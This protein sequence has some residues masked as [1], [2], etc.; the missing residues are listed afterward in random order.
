MRTPKPS[1]GASKRVTVVDC[2]SRAPVDGARLW[3]ILF[4]GDRREIRE[5]VTDALGE[6]DLPD[7]IWPDA[8]LLAR[9]R[10]YVARLDQLKH[11]DLPEL[12][13][14]MPGLPVSGTVSLADGCPAAGAT[15]YAWDLESRGEVAREAALIDPYF[16]D[17]IV[18]D[19]NGCFEIDGVVP[20]QDF[21]LSVVVPGRGV[22]RAVH[23]PEPELR[24]SLAAGGALEGRVLDANGAAVAVAEVYAE[25]EPDADGH[26]RFDVVSIDGIAARTVTD[27]T[28]HYCLVDLA[29]ARYVVT[30]SSGCRARGASK[31]AVIV[32]A[33]DR[34]WRDVT[35]EQYASVSVTLVNPPTPKH[36]SIHCELLHL[37]GSSSW[38]RLWSN[39]YRQG[40]GID[41]IF[42][43]RDGIHPGVYRLEVT[44]YAF[45]ESAVLDTR[46]V[47]LQPGDDF[48]LELGS[49]CARAEDD[50]ASSSTTRH[51]TVR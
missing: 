20:D 26:Y 48:E 3:V 39:S 51:N 31:P 46:V 12:V 47:D 41:E 6:V 14:L 18:A 36:S 29:P 38:S 21:V 43:S 7:A 11:G 28:G 40:E 17:S 42:Y 34:P 23:R 27:D 16:D 35:L 33:H 2:E 8:V 1:W 13:E 30:A 10:G 50:A 44:L 9:K 15:I 32:C 5:G 45:D 24:I 22:Y 25:P 49:R 37:D 19:A 4:D